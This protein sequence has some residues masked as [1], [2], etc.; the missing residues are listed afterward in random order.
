MKGKSPSRASSHDRLSRQDGDCQEDGRI[1]NSARA[2]NA[3]AISVGLDGCNSHRKSLDSTSSRSSSPL[4]PTATAADANQPSL[5]QRRLTN[6]GKS[7]QTAP[8]YA[9]MGIQT[10]YSGSENKLPRLSMPAMQL[11]VPLPPALRLMSAWNDSKDSCG[12]P[13]EPPDKHVHR[14]AIRERVRHFTWTWF[15]MTMATGG[16][17]NVLW[18]FDFVQFAILKPQG[19]NSVN[20]DTPFQIRSVS[21]LS[22]PW[23]ASSSS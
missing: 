8:G 18:V 10:S 15:T 17:A 23:A 22:M 7:G 11:P 16:I 6:Q 1:E 19:A 21:T 5:W 4:S 12:K 3:G 9:N 14:L 13:I 2:S 20:A